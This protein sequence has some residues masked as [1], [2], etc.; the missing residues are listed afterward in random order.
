MDENAGKKKVD[1]KRTKQYRAVRDSI[2][3][4]LRENEVNDQHYLNMV[5]TYM[6]C[7]VDVR[8][9]EDD[10]R[11]RGVNII[12]TG[13]YGDEIKRNES[14]GE[15]IRVIAQMLRILDSLGLKRKET[16]KAKSQGDE[17]DDL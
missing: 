13:R 16:S 9:L 5:I 11:E 1:Y 4:Q 7:W 6:E 17:Y 2:L 3:T 12:T 8:R 15:K 10:I 14:V